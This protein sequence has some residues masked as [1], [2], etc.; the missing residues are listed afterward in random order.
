MRLEIRGISKKGKKNRD[1]SSDCTIISDV[2]QHSQVDTREIFRMELC[3]G[4]K[5]VKGIAKKKGGKK[6][7]GRGACDGPRKTDDADGGSRIIFPSLPG[8]RKK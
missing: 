2:P 5:I 1:P 6:K 7:L 8:R 3:R 4:M